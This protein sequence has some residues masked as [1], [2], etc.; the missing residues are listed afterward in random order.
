MS[1]LTL[2]PQTARRLAITRQRLAGP[3]PQPNSAGILELL[4][5]IR[6]LQIDPIRA[7]ERT[8]Y[9]VLWSRLGPYHPADLDALC[10]KTRQVFEYW[11]HAAS[12]VLTEDYPLH[13]ARMRRYTKTDS[14]WSER[15]QTWLAENN[16]LRQHLYHRLKTEGPLASNEIEDLTVVPWKS[17][18]WNN[19]RN[20]NRMIEFLWQMGELTVA[21]REGIRKKW[22]LTE[23]H[24]PHSVM[25]TTLSNDEVVY[26]AAQHSLRALG[27]GTQ[28]HIKNHFIRD[29]YPNLGQVLQRL[30]DQEQIIPVKIQ[31]E[32]TQ[33]TG[34]WYLHEA[35]VDLAK[36][37]AKDEAWQPRTTL[38]SPFDN[39]IC[40]RDRTE[41]MWSFL[42]R[43]E[44]YVPKAKRQYGYYVLPILHGDQLIGRIDPK[45]DR[46]TDILHI[47]AIYYEPD[48]QLNSETKQAVHQAIE[49]LAKFLGA[50]EV[51][52]TPNLK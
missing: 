7:V 46:K 36:Q 31:D 9:L 27:I 38:L 35:D 30:I 3:R 23:K 47:N 10:W 51:R 28:K 17:T 33:W 19:D 32:T 2:S 20:V 18:G 52:L 26:Q 24:L 39:L 5:D 14:V 11:A 6:C 49:S 12:I 34:Q 50:A 13:Q 8:Q 1:Q 25:S 43:I 45:M 48:Y 42:F 40:D 41:L 4:Q 29:E 22:T 44:I 15:I 16:K 21:A 37:L